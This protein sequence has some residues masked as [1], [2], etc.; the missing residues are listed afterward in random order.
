M[1]ENVFDKGDIEIGNPRLGG[2]VEVPSAV[3]MIDE[4]LEESDFI[5]SGNE[6]FGAISA[7]R[8]PGQRNGHR[9][10]QDAFIRRLSELSIK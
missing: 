9:L 10:V 7:C 8:R 6:R 3:L 2:M 4:V 1:K 5:S